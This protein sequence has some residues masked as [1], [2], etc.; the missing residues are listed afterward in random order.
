MVLTPGSSRLAEYLD[1]ASTGEESLAV[2]EAVDAVNLMTIHTNKW[3]GVR[4]DVFTTRQLEELRKEVLPDK[5]TEE[6]AA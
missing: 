5:T 6:S 4:M 2:L 3:R 1:S